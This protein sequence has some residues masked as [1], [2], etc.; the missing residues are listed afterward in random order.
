MDVLSW[1]APVSGVTVSLTDLK[2][3]GENGP[4][5]AGEGGV[6]SQA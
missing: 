1:K 2:E 5:C 3:R 4:L 6:C